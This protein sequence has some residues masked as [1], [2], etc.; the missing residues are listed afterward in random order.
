[1]H[2]RWNF[3]NGCFGDPALYI[4]DIKTRNALL[5]DCGDLSHFTT[6]QLLKVS[7]IFLSHCHIDHFFGFDHFLRVLVGSEKAVTLVG[8]PQTSERVAGKLQGYTWNL[9]WDQNLEFIV[10][11]LD[12]ETQQKK[13]THFHAKNAFLPTDIKTEAINLKEPI[14][15]SGTFT[16]ST[17]PID[18]RTP[19]LAYSVQEKTSFSVNIEKLQALGF[20]TGPWLNEL[21]QA[22]LTGDLNRSILVETKVGSP[23]GLSSEQLAQDLL[24]QRPQYKISYATDGAAHEKN[25]ASLLPLIQNSD[26]FFSET[27][28]TEA[29]RELADETKHFTAAF[30]GR[31]ASAAGIKKLAPF[32]FSK[33]YMHRSFDVFSELQTKFSGELLRLTTEA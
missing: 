4:W 1:M 27:C 10:I 9:I 30:M 31:L 21:K 33:R 18:H 26:I 17:A 23:K 32:H 25:F 7:H 20:E 3:L 22:Y 11:D 13:T 8:P 16:V 24:I 14:Y 6:R 12:F 19:S 5:V 15:D 2:L 28:F 29:D